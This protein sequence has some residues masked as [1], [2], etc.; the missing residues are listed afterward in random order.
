[1]ED[2]VRFIPFEL[3]VKRSSLEKLMKKEIIGKSY[4]GMSLRVDNVDEVKT[5]INQFMSFNTKI[6]EK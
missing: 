2:Y 1:M 5:L 3:L 6:G 4:I